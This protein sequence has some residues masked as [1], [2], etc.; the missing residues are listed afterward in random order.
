MSIYG[1]Q[2][3][4]TCQNTK[5]SVTDLGVAASSYLVGHLTHNP[6]AAPSYLL[7]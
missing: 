3:E 1:K 6:A 5:V 4:K 2:E 7:V